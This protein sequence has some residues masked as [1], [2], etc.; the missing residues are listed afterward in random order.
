V[1]IRL[2][3]GS[4]SDLIGASVLHFILSGLYVIQLLI[5]CRLQIWETAGGE[6]SGVLRGAKHPSIGPISTLRRI[7]ASTPKQT[8]SF[9]K[10]CI[11]LSNP[12]KYKCRKII[13]T[14][15]NKTNIILPINNLIV[16]FR[17][18]SVPQIPHN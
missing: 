7:T 3:K 9:G 18:T 15:Q 17:P 16:V 1:E 6:A 13:G 14:R 11:L 12:T 5:K 10:K 2:C 8:V 4:M